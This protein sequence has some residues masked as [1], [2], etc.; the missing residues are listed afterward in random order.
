MTKSI[1]EYIKK[2]EIHDMV[3]ARLLEQLDYLFSVKESMEAE[4]KEIS[5]L[6][7]IIIT[8]MESA[9]IEIN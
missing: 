9:G 5:E 3:S 1:V 8:E 7:D 6:I 2:Q 4:V